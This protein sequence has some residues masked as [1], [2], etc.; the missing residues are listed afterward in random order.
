M[1]STAVVTRFA[2][3]PTGELHLGNARTALFS[4]LLA[5]QHGGRFLL[6]IEDTDSGRSLD[7]HAAAL[8]EDLHWLGL[9]WDL[10]PGS[11]APPGE[12]RQS[13][14][15]H[16][17]QA[18]LECLAAG[19]NAYPCFCT[20]AELE[21]SRREQL[22]AGRP[23]R[24]AGTCRSLSA[25]GQA[26]QRAAGRRAAWRFRVPRGERVH[27][28][29]LVHGAQSIAS[30][31]LGDFV[32]QR[33]DGGPAFFF[34]NAID[35]ALMQVTHVLR[36]EDH[37][38][39]TPRQL[40]ILRALDLP[41]PHYAHV[42]LLSGTDGVPLSK[43]HGATSLRAYRASG[44]APQA[45]C[46]HLFRLGHSTTENGLLGLEAM[47]RRFDVA[48]LQRAPARFDAVQLT[49]WQSL[50]V[51]SQTPQQAAAW[52]GEALAGVPMERRDAFVSA[53]LPNVTLAEDARVWADIVFADAG[54]EP[55]P[56]A[57]RAIAAAGPAFFARAAAAL[58][59]G[60]DLERLRAATGARGAALFA[61]LRA[62]LTGRLHGPDF[63]ALLAL[64]P[65]ATLQARLLKYA[66]G[67]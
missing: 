6:R 20:P 40:L 43:R 9:D 1:S 14:R 5:R 29:D 16:V 47:A 11:G 15:R 26:A 37:L 18:Q 19:G 67:A 64:L 27:F 24:Y 55:E 35:D 25:A 52:L 12:W 10:G 31:E 50:W 8:A 60:A 61:P 21:Q 63:G 58:A 41:A 48:R 65:V 42:A 45:L 2:P 51:R 62:A 54:V 22:A 59:D 49:H 3:S 30:D 66:K 4:W 57:A 46:N 28:E 32:L 33:A 53:V 7:A 17:Y 44:Y 23:P 36:G 13:A 56:V 39:N 34:C 38:A